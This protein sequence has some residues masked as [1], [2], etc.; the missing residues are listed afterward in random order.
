VTAT[1]RKGRV[2]EIGC[3][4]TFVRETD[5]RGAWQP[6]PDEAAICKAC[7][8]RANVAPPRSVWA[9]SRLPTRR[10]RRRQVGPSGLRIPRTASPRDWAPPIHP[11]SMARLCSANAPKG[12]TTG[13]EKGAIAVRTRAHAPPSQPIAALHSD[14][15]R[16][17]ALPTQIVEEPPMSRRRG[18][19]PTRCAAALRG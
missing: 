7:R 2:G 10:L 13:I 15:L 5:R 14:I 3:P 9:G 6:K 11:P 17:R 1:A 16:R 4:R 19:S 8:V 12:R 18:V